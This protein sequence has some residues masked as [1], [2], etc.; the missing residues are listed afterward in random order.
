MMSLAAV[1]S[2]PIEERIRKEQSQ[3]KHKNKQKIN[4]T[5]ALAFI[6]YNMIELIL[7][8]KIRKGL[9]ALDKILSKTKEIVRPGRTN[10]RKKIKKKP[11]SS[12]YK[13]L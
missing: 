11:P 13:H 7:K 10:P 12:N 2:F 9:S 5:N 4:R 3:T 6:K 8:Q 1:L